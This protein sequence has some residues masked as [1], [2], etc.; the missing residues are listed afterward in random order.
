MTFRTRADHHTPTIVNTIW[1][2]L[3][4]V[5][6]GLRDGH[7]MARRYHV[8]SRMSDLE[9]R[10]RGLKRSQITRAVAMGRTKL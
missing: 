9:L 7:E 5:Y 2:T 6:E 1:R 4:A 10:K 8:L 3:A